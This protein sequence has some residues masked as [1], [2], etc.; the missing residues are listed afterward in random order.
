MTM[1]QKKTLRSKLLRGSLFG[2]CLV[3]PVWSVVTRV[4]PRNAAPPFINSV[5]VQLPP[6]AAPPEVQVLRT[7]QQNYKYMDQSVTGYSNV[8]GTYLLAEPLLR[9]DRDFNLLPAA[10]THWQVSDDGLTWYFYL[11]P[12]LIFTDGRPVT[13]HDYVGTFRIWADPKTGYDFEWYYHAI[14]NWQAVVSGKIPVQDLGIR[15]IDD[16]TLAI[17]TERPAPYL[18]ALLNFSQL[19]PVHA[20]EKYGSAWSTRPE[21]SISSGPFMLE[22]WDKANQVVLVANPRYR[23]PA[24]PFL[25]KLVANL[26][27]PSAPPPFLAAYQN[28]EVDYIQ[29]TFQAQLSRIKTDPVLWEQLNTFADFMTYYL[30]MDTYGPPFDDLRVRQAFSHAI[31]REALVKSAL[32]EVGVPAYTMLQSGFPGAM[33]DALASIQRY[34]PDLARQRLA[35]AGFPNGK[36]FPKLDLW[37]RNTFTSPTKMAAEAIQAMLKQ[38]LN[39]DIGVSNMGI[40]LFTDALNKH[41]IAIA[42][43]PY[44]YD[45]IDAGNLLDVWRSHGRHAWHNDQ[46]EDLVLNA[47]LLMGDEAGRLARYQEAERI[48]VSDVGGIFLWHELVNEMWKPYVRGAALEPNRLNFRAW[49][50][51]GKHLLTPTLYITREKV[52]QAR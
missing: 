45:Y 50:G 27:V 18:P 15:A 10:A 17:S 25:E 6:D 30:T 8:Y 43:V 44:R 36:G 7:L 2:I 14:K 42:L 51:D 5:G 39:I 28:N 23:G 3:I 12:E 38:T 11:R 29:L 16:H 41:E 22:S 46:F 24:K 19:T 35:E 26:Y 48:L 32:R 21:T 9:M 37:L 33:P 20:I 4:V 13:A 47:N 52:D 1:P 40:K 49:R 34:D 31:D